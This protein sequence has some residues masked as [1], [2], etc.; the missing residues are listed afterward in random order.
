MSIN[1]C[2]STG[3]LYIDEVPFT[4]DHLKKLRK[5]FRY[6]KK[7]SQGQFK[8]EIVV[9]DTGNQPVKGCIKSVRID[10]VLIDDIFKLYDVRNLARDKDFTM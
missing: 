9:T 10:A 3:L 8:H 2:Q 4:K 6:E 1:K 7:C 5:L